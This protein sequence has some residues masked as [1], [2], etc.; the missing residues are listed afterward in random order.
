MS[1][2][3]GTLTWPNST[4]PICG[5]ADLAA[6]GPIQATYTAGSGASQ[7]GLA[8]QACSTSNG[9]SPVQAGQTCNQS[10]WRPQRQDCA[11]S[12]WPFPAAAAHC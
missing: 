3:G 8:L 4:N 7:Y 2:A 11:R 9:C 10:L 6:A 1:S 12:T 5:T